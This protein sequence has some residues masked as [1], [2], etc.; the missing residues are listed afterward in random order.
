LEILAYSQNLEDFNAK[1]SVYLKHC[2]EIGNFTK[3][4]LDSSYFLR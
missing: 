1:N 4:V 3:T 2:D